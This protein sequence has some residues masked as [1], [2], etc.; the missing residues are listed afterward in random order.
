MPTHNTVLLPRVTAACPCNLGASVWFWLCLVSEQLN[1]RKDFVDN[2]SWCTSV[3]HLW[4]PQAP[5][6]LFGL[7]GY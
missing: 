3:E 4:L 1:A 5:S 2:S 7:P 6:W